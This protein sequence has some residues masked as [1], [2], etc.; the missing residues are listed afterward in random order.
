KWTKKHVHQWDNK[1]NVTGVNMLNASDS[2]F[3]LP[4]A[5]L[6]TPTTPIKVIVFNQYLNP[7]GNLAVGPGTFEIS[8]AHYPPN[9][10]PPNGLGSLAEQANAT[11]AAAL[12]NAMP[13][14]QRGSTLERLI[15]NL[16]KTAFNS[17]D[18][19]TAKGGSGAGTVRAGMIPT[20]TGC[21]N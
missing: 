5:L 12:I 8:V 6:I 2:G 13:S 19:W 18:W 3:N 11:D 7:A 15:V 4:T 17:I 16:P 21:V 14:Y 9:T 10:N 20:Q 1:W